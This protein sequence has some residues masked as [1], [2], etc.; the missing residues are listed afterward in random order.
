[1][2]SLL[3]I[4][5]HFLV[6]DHPLEEGRLIAFAAEPFRAQRFV[7]SLPFPYPYVAV[8]KMQAPCCLLYPAL[9]PSSQFLEMQSELPIS[10][11]LEGERGYAGRNSKGQNRTI[12]PWFLSSVLGHSQ[13]PSRLLESGM[14]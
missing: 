8:E 7:I 9:R 6:E 12:L 1:M 14:L 4:H 5:L 11:D 13:L 2:F 10:L 3:S